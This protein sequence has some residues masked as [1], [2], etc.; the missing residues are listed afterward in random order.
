METITHYSKKTIWSFFVAVFLFAL[1]LLLVRL[2][3]YEQTDSIQTPEQFIEVVTDVATKVTQDAFTPEIAPTTIYENE[4]QYIEVTEGCGPQ[5][6]E[7]D[8]LNVRS[9]PG[10][11][12]PIVT[13]LRTGVV[14]KVG[15]LIENESGRWYKIIFDEWL[16]YPNRVSEN[17]FISAD[18]VREFNNV[19]PLDFDENVSSTSINK[20]ILIDRSDQTLTAYEDDEIFFEISIST[21]LELSPTP[22]GNFTV[23]KK[24]PTRYMQGP[25]PGIPGSHYYDLPGVPWNLYFTYEGAVIHGAYWHDSFGQPYSNGC[26]NLSLA[27]AERLYHWADVGTKV[28]V[29]D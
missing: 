8:C 4:V 25:I 3:L 12:F 21:G 11:T 9:G 17:W 27:D 19:G 22:R 15:E 1:L 2:S 23:Y 5:F 29:R 18:Y 24:T 14:L 28:Q 16:R 20:R 26:V 10:T 6:D 13:Q 7:T